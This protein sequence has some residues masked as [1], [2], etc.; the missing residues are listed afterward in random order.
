MEPRQT[1]FSIY[2]KFDFEYKPVGIKFLMSR[3]EGIEKLDKTMALCEMVSEAQQRGIPFYITRENE[4]CGGAMT[5][6]M[7]DP[8][9]VAESGQ[10]GMKY[11]IF[12]EPRA[13]GKMNMQAPAFPR[14]T[15][16][17]VVFAPID[18]LTFEPDI[19]V[20]VATSAQAEIIL[21]AASYSTG[22]IW[23]SKVSMVG[24]CAWLFTYPYQSGNI[25]YVPT[26]MTFGMKSRKVYPEGLI[27]LYIPFNWMPI[28]TKNLGQMEWV[29]PSYTDTREQ[30]LARHEKVMAEL[31]KDFQNP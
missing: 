27:M 18:K 12:Q 29:L 31:A 19:L 1:D 2:E 13:N 9:P 15:V 23:T 26:S 25:N 3:P 7:E 30:F 17:Y 24:A 20:V 14:G 22:E 21:R 28:I 6:G 11:G 16:K 5:L 8:S 4:D 10:V